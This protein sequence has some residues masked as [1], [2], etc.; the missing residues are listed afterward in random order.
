MIGSIINPSLMPK[1]EKLALA[2]SGGSDSMALMHI[3]ANVQ[4][5]DPGMVTVL[6]V[7]HG[8]RSQSAAEARFVAHAARGYGFFQQTLCWEGEKPANGIQEAARNARYEL[9]TSYCLANGIKSLLTA[10]H[11][12][13]QAE[14]V[15]MRLARGSGVNGLTA[16]TGHSTMN[17]V[18]I[19]RPLLGIPK[20]GLRE[21]L[22]KAN[23]NWL[24]DP[25]NNNCDY[26]R[27]RLREKI[28]EL[29]AI[30]LQAKHIAKT[31][32][33]MQRARNA[34]EIFTS[35][36]LARTAK[37]YPAG[38]CHMDAEDFLSSPPEIV[39]RGLARVINAVRGSR[40]H[41]RMKK[42]EKVADIITA[43]KKVTKT[44]S[45]C[46]ILRDKSGLLVCR[47]H[48]RKGLP[49][50]ILEPG[51]SRMWDARFSVKS[52]PDYHFDVSV[53]A[54][55][56]DGL[57]QIKPHI[58]SPLPIPAEAAKTTPSFWRKGRPV[59]A[60]LLEYYDGNE[61]KKLQASLAVRLAP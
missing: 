32:M 19:L 21:I 31:A 33:R 38:F 20:S 59:C 10:H 15:L 61:A 9:M 17:D 57:C 56:E 14:T 50:V 2:V 28:P 25:S 8:L 18:A 5:I 43:E 48:G 49:E 55:G 7:D 1:D 24:E 34:L 35:E 54:L 52:S 30:G 47:E 6:S 3:V 42:L 58:T 11:L 40:E 60:P 37:L 22:Q 39:L 51:Q 13:D 4:D 46:K 12:D 26:E 44:L 41:I 29:A 16:M 23:I 27:A 53:R 45:E 36:V